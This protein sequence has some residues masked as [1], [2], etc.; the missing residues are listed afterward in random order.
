M[1]QP[2]YSP[3]LAPCDFFL[4]PKLKRPM[5]GQRYATLDEIKMAS[6]ERVKNDFLKCFEDWKNRWYKCIISH[7]DYFDG[8]KIEGLS[9]FHFGQLTTSLV[10][11]S[12]RPEAGFASCPEKN[13]SKIFCTSGVVMTRGSVEI[14]SQRWMARHKLENSDE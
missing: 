2:L 12:C 9:Q 3:D 5:K 8:D 7:G 10:S 11:S 4:F 6:K 1:P 13:F 14:E